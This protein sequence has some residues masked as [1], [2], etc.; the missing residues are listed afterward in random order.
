MREAERDIDGGFAGFAW[1]MRAFLPSLVFRTLPLG[2]L[3]R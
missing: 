1:T 3:W 2:F